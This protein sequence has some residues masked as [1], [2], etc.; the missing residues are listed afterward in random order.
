MSG[1]SKEFTAAVQTAARRIVTESGV[2]ITQ[3]VTIL[4]LAKRLMQD[5]NCG[6]D[7]AKQHIAR[8]VRR[9]RGE[10]VE[11]AQQGGKRTGAG[12]PKREES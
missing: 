1:K 10:P 4:P 3:K 9:L 8:V 7:T 2:D 6:I 5:A 11:V 12:R